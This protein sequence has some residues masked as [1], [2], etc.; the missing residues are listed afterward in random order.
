MGK[1]R[2]E[3]DAWGEITVAVD[4]F[5][6]AQTQRA[7]THF[8]TGAGRDI[9]PREMIRALALVKRAAALANQEQGLLDAK[10]AQAIAQACDEMAEG[11]FDGHFPL[12]VWQSGSGTQSHMNANEVIAHRAAAILGSAVHPNDHVNMSQSTNDVFPTA[13]HVAA[14]QAIKSDLIPAV[15]G[16][17]DTLRSK[18]EAFKDVVKL[19]RTH[20]M[21]AVPLT[22]GQEMSGWCQML[23]NGLERVELSLPHLYELPLGGTAV[24][25]GLNSRSGFGEMAAFRL[26]QATGLPFVAAPNKFEALAA[27]DAII[28]SHGTLK[29]LALSLAKIAGDVRWLASGPRAGLGEISIPANEP[30][31]SIMPG[32]ANP[33]Q[34]EAL[35]MVCW[36]VVGNDAAIAAANAAANFELHTAQPLLM[37]D[38]LESVR[39]LCAACRGFDEHCC[40]GLKPDSGRIKGFLDASLMLVTVLSPRIGHEAAAQI[41]RAASEEGLTLK[42]AAVRSGLVTAKQFDS[43]VKP[44]E[45]THPNL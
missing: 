28:F 10:K 43:W 11:K 31:S 19:G 38:F 33:T 3:K 41:A 27:R 2:V 8:Q 45:M 42:E 12:S 26:E 35:L 36:Q 14:A 6:G 22:L 7:L 23:A 9:L 39:L 18:S 15:S 21:D 37:H 40:R 17:L 34:C 32:K 16:L 20:L 5:W 13:L 1:T 25:T 29:S 4:R 30:G 24:G 44:E